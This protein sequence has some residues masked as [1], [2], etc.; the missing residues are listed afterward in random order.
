[1]ALV[2]SYTEKTLADFLNTVLGPTASALGWSSGADDAGDY[3]EPVNDILIA[4]GVQDVSEA[5]DIPKVRVLAR[6]IA[7]RWAADALA[8]R[9]NTVVGGESLARRALY[10]NAVK[11][12]DYWLSAATSTGLIEE[13]AVTLTSIVHADDPHDA[14]IR[15]ATRERW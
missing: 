9:Y 2:T 1:M 15:Y 13:Y 6:W 4:Y 10:E 8:S 14:P 11:Q 3:E 12:R 5:T 7:W